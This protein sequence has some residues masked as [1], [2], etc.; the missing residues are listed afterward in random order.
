MNNVSNVI[1]VLSK[2]IIKLTNLIMH[3]YHCIGILII[4]MTR[5]IPHT[6]AM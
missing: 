3:T 1:I 6:Y 5:N 4:Q 2:F